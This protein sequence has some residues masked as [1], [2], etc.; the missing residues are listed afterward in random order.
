[1]APASRRRAVSVKSETTR[2]LSSVLYRSGLLGPVSSAVGYVRRVKGFPI[3]AFHRVNDDDD[4]FMPA[5]PTALFAAPMEHI[6]RH[7]TVLTVEDLVERP[8][9]GRVPP[10]AVALTFDDG[11]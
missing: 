5:L 3:L 6:G 10:E 8:R 9:P 7:Y 11:H 1:M 4:P 2:V